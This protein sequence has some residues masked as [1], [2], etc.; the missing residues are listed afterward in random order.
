MPRSGPRGWT[1]SWARVRSR[2]RSRLPS[3]PRK[4]AAGD[5]G[6]HPVLRTARA[7]QDHPGHA[8]GPGDGGPAPHH[9]GAG[10]GEAGRPRRPAHLAR[11]GRHA[12][13]RRD[14]P[15][16]AGAGGVPLSRHGGLPDRRADRGG[17][18]RPDHPDDTGAVHP[19]RRHHPLRPAHPADAG[20]VRHRGAA[21]LLPARGA[22]ADRDRSAG[23]PRRADR[24]RGRRPRS[25][26]GAGE[27]RGSPTG[28][29]GGCG[30]TPR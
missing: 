26:G 13:H 16:E 19:D 17:A 24:G 11:A 18:Q 9:L 27:R 5:P 7:G 14:P 3:T 8:H 15:A 6:P 12:V 28:C 10:A 23:D 22:A 25:P 21:R 20:P 30:T 29:C 1:S 4:A 2:P